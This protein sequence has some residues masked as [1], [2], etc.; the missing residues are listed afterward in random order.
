LKAQYLP[1]STNQHNKPSTVEN[2]INIYKDN[3]INVKEYKN[4]QQ[5]IEQLIIELNSREQKLSNHL[6]EKNKLEKEREEIRKQIDEIKKERFLLREQE[7]EFSDLIKKESK[8]IR[9][10]RTTNK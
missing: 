5:I 1:N 9:V 4:K 6:K 7:N 10:I 8:K 3:A 2:L